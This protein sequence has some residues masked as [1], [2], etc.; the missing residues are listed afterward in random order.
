MSLISQ[1]YIAFLRSHFRL[2]WEGIHGAPHWARVRANGLL[3]AKQTGAD[4]QIVEAF[5]FIHDAER[6]SDASDPEHGARAAELAATINDEFFQLTP[7]QLFRLMEACEDHSLGD[8]VG[9]IT[10]L[11]CWDADRLDL[12]RVGIKPRKDKLCTTAA[13]QKTMIEWAYSRSQQ[14]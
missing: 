8:T 5:A 9:D 12:G 10:V 4:T 7:E 11:T 14:I 3:L 1:S 6:W 13:K 2:E